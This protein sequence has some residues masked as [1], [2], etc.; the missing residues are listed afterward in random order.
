MAGTWQAG[1]RAA[2]FTLKAT[3]IRLCLALVSTVTMAA[4]AIGRRDLNEIKKGDM[5]EAAPG[6]R[7][8]GLSD[9][10]AMLVSFGSARCGDLN[11]SIGGSPDG[12]L[13]PVDGHHRHR[14]ES[15]MVPIGDVRGLPRRDCLWPVRPQPSWLPGIHNV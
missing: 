7:R 4:L 6:Q 10:R 2:C 14:L 8:L 15:D 12:R 13:D 5:L 3:V 1:N 11:D 9:V